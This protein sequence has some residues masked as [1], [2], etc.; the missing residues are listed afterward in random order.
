MFV[1][2]KKETQW[3]DGI[4]SYQDWSRFKHNYSATP[5][6]DCAEEI[7]PNAS[8]SRGLGLSNRAFTDSDHVGDHITR[9]FL[10]LS[11]N[12]LVFKK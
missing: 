11:A 7:P 12:L 10:K 5:Y 9:R 2:L 1:F 4:T 3:G 6:S 8:E